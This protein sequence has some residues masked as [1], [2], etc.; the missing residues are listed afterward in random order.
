MK[1]RA[2]PKP[3]LETSDSEE[4]DVVDCESKL[5]IGTQV[6]DGSEDL[7]EQ[8]KE[9]MMTFKAKLAISK[10]CIEKISTNEQELAFYT[11]FPNYSC[12][13]ACYDSWGLQLMI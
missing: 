7:I 4:A 3:P 6:S 10:F 1:T 13:K 11:G 9:S 5:S 8:L 12:F 2:I